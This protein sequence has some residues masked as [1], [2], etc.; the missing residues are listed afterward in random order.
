M[1]WPNVMQAPTTYSLTYSMLQTLFQGLCYESSRPMPPMF[2]DV[3]KDVNDIRSR[4]MV[5]SETHDL[6][7]L[8]TIGINP[9]KRSGQTSGDYPKNV[10]H[11]VCMLQMSFEV[12]KFGRRAV[13]SL[14]KKKAR[15]RLHCFSEPIFRAHSVPHKHRGL[16]RLDTK[17]GEE[18]L[19]VNGS[20][21]VGIQKAGQ[22]EHLMLSDAEAAAKEAG[23]QLLSVQ[24]AAAITVE[25]DEC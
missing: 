19:H 18:L 16:H 6:F 23:G 22:R 4:R 17:F 11:L 1:L 8:L 7:M 13:A 10:H 15:Q 2:V 24:V 20:G 14:A 3:C 25:L 5:D 12:L 9:S 21:V